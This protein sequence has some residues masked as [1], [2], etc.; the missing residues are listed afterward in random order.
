[1]IANASR[2]SLRFMFVLILCC[3]MMTAQGAFAAPPATSEGCDP[4][5]QKA[6]EARA[7]VKVAYDVDVTEEHDEKPDST[8]ATTCLNDLSG[9]QSSGSTSLP[10]GGAGD[11]SIFSGDF[12][13]A[14]PS[15]EAGGLRADIQDSLQNFYTDFMDAM[16]ADSGLVDYTQTALTANNSCNETQDLWTQ[17]KQGGVEE[18]VPNATLTDLL[19]GTLP[20]GANKDYTDDWTTET[21]NDN[22]MSNYSSALA[23]QP[24]AYTPTITQ[25]DGLCAAQSQAGIL[26]APGIG[27][28]CP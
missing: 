15:G 23:A 4:Q 12:T 14:A 19:N 11:G 8:M 27:P 17:V 3:L 7:E 1:M 6:Q 13:N 16:G 9:I 2:F 25:T 24:P 21:T 20:G 28:A 26:G 18:G 22:N 10:G 5:V